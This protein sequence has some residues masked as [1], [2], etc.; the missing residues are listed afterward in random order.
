VSPRLARSIVSLYSRRWQTRYGDEFVALLESLP[1]TASNVIDASLPALGRQAERV[2][3][4]LVIAACAAM[5]AAGVVRC[6]RPD[7]LAAWHTGRRVS[8]AQALCRPLPKTSQSAYAD[9]RRCL[10]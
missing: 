10:D 5:S 8:A 7:P 1:P 3:I 2:A 6:V 4:G 9:W